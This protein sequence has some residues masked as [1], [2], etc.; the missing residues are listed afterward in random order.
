VLK[1][2]DRMIVGERSRVKSGDGSFC[3]ILKEVGDGLAV[4]PLDSMIEF[5]VKLDRF[6]RERPLEEQIQKE[7]ERFRLS[8]AIW[9]SKYDLV[10]GRKPL[11]DDWYIIF[12]RSTTP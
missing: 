8:Q 11:T 2:I 9:A 1:K 7:R 12:P 5:L 10:H 4:E 3:P 6:E